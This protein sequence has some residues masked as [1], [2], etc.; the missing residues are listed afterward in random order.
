MI[1]DFTHL[2]NLVAHHIEA[3]LDGKKYDVKIDSDVADRLGLTTRALTD[4]C[5]SA[6]SRYSQ[7]S[8]R[9]NSV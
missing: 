7:V 8:R 6:T 4:C 2:A 9:Y 1:C 5:H 3:L